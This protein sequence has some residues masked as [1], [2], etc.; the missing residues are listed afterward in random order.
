MRHEMWRNH[1]FPYIH[2]FDK[3]IFEYTSRDGDTRACTPLRACS[4]TR[5]VDRDEASFALRPPRDTLSG[6]LPRD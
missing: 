2:L 3:Y 4:Q 1:R 5:G 6:A